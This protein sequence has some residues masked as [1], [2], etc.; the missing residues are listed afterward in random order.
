MPF[1]RRYNVSAMCVSCVKLLV[2]Q[3]LSSETEIHPQYIFGYIFDIYIQTYIRALL[4]SQGD[5]QR[6]RHVC[7]Y[8]CMYVCMHA[9]MYVWMYVCM[10]VRTYAACIHVRMHACISAWLFA[11]ACACMHAYRHGCFRARVHA[12]ARASLK[13]V[14]EEYLL[15]D[16][17]ASNQVGEAARVPNI[18]SD[19][20][21]HMLVNALTGLSAILPAGTVSCREEMH[22]LCT[23]HATRT[24]MARSVCLIG[25]SIT[26]NAC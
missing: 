2:V 18:F 10:Y 21:L 23:K 26:R 15:M 22:P 4:L 11:C 3:V 14:I 13:Y 24:W 8:I 9:C 20:L 1:Y 5:R 19:Y 12:C 25:P 7:M 16:D 17:N 6:D